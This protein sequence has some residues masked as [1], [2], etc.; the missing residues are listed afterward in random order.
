MAAYR[1]LITG[2]HKKWPRAEIIILSLWIGFWQE[3]ETFHENGGWKSEIYNDVYRYFT[4][5]KGADYLHYFNTTGVLQHNDMGPGT[6][7]PND[8][9]RESSS[10]E[11]LFPRNAMGTDMFLKYLDLKLAT[12]LMQYIKLKFG[13]TFES[14]GP[15]VFPYPDQQLYN[16]DCCKS[17][18]LRT[19]NFGFEIE[20]N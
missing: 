12:H 16:T 6:W 17:T 4:E 2:V 8:L 15:Q 18:L 10:N 20:I 1:E 3:R 7:H 19:D 13:W 5:T 14:A 11:L 9:G